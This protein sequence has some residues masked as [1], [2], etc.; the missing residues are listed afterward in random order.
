[1]LII[2]RCGERAGRKTGRSAR[3]ADNQYKARL[4]QRLTDGG[5]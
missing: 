2:D 5:V 1:V 3:S 4:V